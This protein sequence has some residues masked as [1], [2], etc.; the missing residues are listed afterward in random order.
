MKNIRYWIWGALGSIA[1]FF[2]GFLLRQPQ[3][4]DLKKQIKRLQT[5]NEI[6]QNLCTKQKNEFKE[7]YVQ[8]KA[9]KA[10]TLNKKIAKEKVKENLIF[11]Y[12]LKDYIELLVKRVKYEKELTKREI[13]FFKSY[14][15]VID[16]K[17]ITTSDKI[18]IRDYTLE[19][20]SVNINLL[21][22][23]DY[24]KVITELNN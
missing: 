11:Q 2:F 1:L 17:N 10:F 13:Q 19:K 23:C 3:I 16:G 14:E 22:E 4:N 21:K 6:L 9:F 24:S 5:D 12:A 15:K 20:H 8:Y 18:K 7:L